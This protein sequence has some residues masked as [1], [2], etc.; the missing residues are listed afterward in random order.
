MIEERDGW[1]VAVIDEIDYEGFWGTVEAAQLALIAY[2]LGF[3]EHGE[4]N[5]FV[6]TRRMDGLF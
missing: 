4:I 2:N 6:N 1:F 5:R 3:K